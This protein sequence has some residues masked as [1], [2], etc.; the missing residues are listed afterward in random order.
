MQQSLGV[1]IFCPIDLS[2]LEGGQE[3]LCVLECT[4]A[5]EENVL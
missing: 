1:L 5:W 2:W 4:E 3:V